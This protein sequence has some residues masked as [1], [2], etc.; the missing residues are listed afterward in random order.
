M[1]DNFRRWGMP[2]G[3][4]IPLW[5]LLQWWRNQIFKVLNSDETIRW[6]LGKRKSRRNV[7]L[8]W[9]VNS[10]NQGYGNKE[11]SKLGESSR[12][13]HGRGLKPIFNKNIINTPGLIKITKPYRIGIVQ[14]IGSDVQKICHIWL[15]NLLILLLR[16][17]LIVNGWI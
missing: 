11:G 8:T 7:Y 10:P 6:I 9:G 17:I 16:I 15:I 13:I 3:N 12:P 5:D 1:Q 4:Y 14:N 2:N